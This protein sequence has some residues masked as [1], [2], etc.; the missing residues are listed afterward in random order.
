MKRIEKISCVVLA[1][2]QGTRMK[3]NLPKVLHK[4][5]DR[6]MLLYCLDTLK[7]LKS[8]KIVV[9]VAEKHKE[10]KDAVSNSFNVTFAVQ[11]E[12]KGTAHA[13]LQASSF[14]RNTVLVTNGDAP[15]ITIATLRKFLSLH[16]KNKNSVSMLSFKAADP[17]SYGR[18][19]RDKR[20]LPIRVVEEKDASPR[21]KEIQEVN[22]G[23]Y[24]IE[25]NALP[26]LNEIKLNKKKGE[27]YLT[28]IIHVAREKGAAVGVYQIGDEEEFLG[29]NTRQDLAM[30]NEVLRKKTILELQEKGVVIMDAN[31]VYIWPSVK[32]GRDTEIYP[33]VL[34]QG[35]T[36]IGKRCTIYPNVRIIDSRIKESAVIKDSTLIENSSVG[37]GAQVGP[38]SHIRPESSIG[39]SAKIG[40]F[41][42][43]KKSNIGKG[44]KAMHLSYLG[45]ATIGKEVNIGAGTITCNYDG[46]R[47]H[48]TLIEDEVFVGSDTQLV[49]PVKLGKGSYIGAG[50]TITKD[51]PSGDLAVSRT[52]QKSLKGWAKKKR[53]PA[54]KRRSTK[55]R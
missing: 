15:H 54:T 52:E 5:Y 31:S 7:M 27:Y 37:A 14:T 8:E 38:F 46:K 13:L 49:A 6:P 33:N 42:E 18:I 34:I 43:V 17:S 39:D 45:D 1:A 47:K 23:V 2:G 50:S 22:S 12:Q 32:I 9:V 28:D 19:I 16:R 4:L 53:A 29:I 21:E 35:N 41:V 11:K 30:A 51:V 24:A 55:K 10:I 26:F 48:R 40:N 20:G 36:V 25:P 3:S 44:T